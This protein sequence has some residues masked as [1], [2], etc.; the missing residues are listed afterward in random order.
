MHITLFIIIFVEIYIIKKETVICKSCCN[1]FEKNVKEINRSIK[2]G[3]EQYCSRSCAGKSVANIN[4]LRNVNPLDASNLKKY[5]RAD[6]YSSFKTH[7][8]RIKN[9]NKDYNVTLED[10]SEQWDKQNG[11]CIYSKVKLMHPVTGFNSH[12]YTASVD[13]IDSS[14]GYIKENIQFISIA[15]NHM[16]ANMPEKEVHELINIIKTTNN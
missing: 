2:L 14:L 15:M 5:T 10:L 11:V 9:R 1:N 3:R 13:R 4:H 6:K 16:K 12:I 8:R 7:L